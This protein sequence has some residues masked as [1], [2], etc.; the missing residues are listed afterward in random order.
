MISVTIERPDAAA[1]AA[2]WDELAPH[3]TNVFMHP[4]ALKAASETLLTVIY[5][6]LAWDTAVEPHRLVGWWA[7]GERQLGFWPYLE[8]LPFNYAFLSTPVVNPDYAGEVMPAFLAAIARDRALPA[9]L[10]LRDFDAAGPL[11]GSLAGLEGNARARIK[12]DERPSATRAAGI[13]RSGST[14]KKLRQDWNRLAATGALEMVNLGGRAAALEG[15]EAFLQMELRSWKGAGGTALLNDA[16]D[17]AFARRLVGDLAERNAA[18]VALLRLDGRPIAAQVLL[19]AG[20]T[21]YTWKTSYDPSFAKYSPRALLVDRITTELIDSGAVDAIDSC[22]VGQGFMASLWSGRRPMV[23]MVVAARSG[24]SPA[25]LAVAGYF[26]ARQLAKAVRDRVLRRRRRAAARPGPT[27]STPTPP[28]PDAPAT[29]PAPV[30][31]APK[32]DRAA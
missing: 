27:G 25:F 17:A 12:T 14:R 7:L 30:S 26:R 13:K 5:V 29:A 15:L 6:L 11:Y 4:A 19:Y 3:A 23:D 8:A 1:L 10:V 31:P 16:K 32:V 18:S 9:T 2:R 20:R 24:F 22:S 21:A 28:A